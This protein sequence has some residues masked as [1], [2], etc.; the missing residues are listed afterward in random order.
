MLF[1]PDTTPYYLYVR[2]IDSVAAS[3]SIEPITA[4]VHDDTEIHHAI[5][6]GAHGSNGGLLILPD[7]FNAEHRD[8]IIGE[9]A[10]YGLPAV[11]PFEF[12]CEAGV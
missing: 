6:A 10:R 7:I 9:A 4:P 5:K 8:L 2:Y 1:N 11:Y 3:F 12:S